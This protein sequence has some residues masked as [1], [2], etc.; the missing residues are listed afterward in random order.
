[1]LTNLLL[2]NLVSALAGFVLLFAFAAAVVGDQKW[3]QMPIPLDRPN[4]RDGE[5]GVNES[6][7]PSRGPAVP[8]AKLHYCY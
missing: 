3:P 7:D 5:D 2:K 1:M 6:P 8:A 4:A